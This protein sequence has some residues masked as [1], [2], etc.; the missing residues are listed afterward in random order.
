MFWGQHGH[1]QMLSDIYLSGEY[2]RRRH[3]RYRKRQVIGSP[4]RRLAL[5]TFFC[6]F[7][8]LSFCY[9][10]EFCNM[11]FSQTYFGNGALGKTD[12][13]LS[14]MAFSLVGGKYGFYLKYPS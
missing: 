6:L 11:V 13:S 2:M 14:E 7:I 4:E 9:K 8:L 5:C 10:E 1:R 12:I 3:Y